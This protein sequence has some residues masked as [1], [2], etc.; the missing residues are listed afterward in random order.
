LN[1]LKTMPYKEYLQ[2]EHWKGVRKR[3]LSRANYKCQLCGSKETL[4]IHH[5]TYDNR[6]CEKDEDLIAL[7]Q[8]CHGRYHDV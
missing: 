2:T 6:G 3:A 7:C 1:K 4:N 8:N 5:N